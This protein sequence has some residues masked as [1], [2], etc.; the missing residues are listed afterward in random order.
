[1]PTHPIKTS[2]PN[3]SPEI[4]PVTKDSLWESYLPTI[5]EYKGNKKAVA[6]LQQ[7]L[8]TKTLQP[9]LLSGATGSGKTALI[10]ALLT[11]FSIFEDHSNEPLE[12]SF[13]A[14]TKLSLVHT[15]PVAVI[16]ETIEG[17]D[18]KIL[19][20]K[21]K[22]RKTAKEN[23]FQLYPFLLLTC[24]DIDDYTIPQFTTLKKLCHVVYIEKL[25]PTEIAELITD[26]WKRNGVACNKQLLVH[27]LQNS[28]GNP[29]YA[30]NM[31]QFSSK[32]S[33][34]DDFA[35]MFSHCAR[36]C[37]GK[38]GELSVSD[39]DLSLSTLH[40]NYLDNLK[41]GHISKISDLFS[42][43]DITRQDY[44]E[45]SPYMLQEGLRNASKPRQGVPRFF[46]PKSYEKKRRLHKAE[47]P[48]STL[49]ILDRV[50]ENELLKVV[51]L[52]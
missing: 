15:K 21:I 23:M 16:V 36:L 33:G 29:R 47:L 24:D 20:Q 35:D 26:T 42:V 49:P 12:E 43:C 13:Q 48:F 31:A 25:T 27:I 44:N 39:M 2:T 7:Y 18:L 40:D 28:N 1:V 46:F 10:K 38:P 45:I 11:S 8:R 4:P 34:M 30:L 41:P 51:K 3:I 9:I 32:T 17:I 50:E 6:Q 14:L 22:A 52:L 5:Q 37:S 19:Q